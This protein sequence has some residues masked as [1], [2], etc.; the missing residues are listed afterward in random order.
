MKCVQWGVFVGILLLCVAVGVGLW[1]EFCCCQIPCPLCYLQRA[2]M[3]GVGVSL[4][5]NLASSVQVK[6]F[7]LALLWNIF[8]LFFALR[9]IAINVCHLPR[10]TSFYF[11]SWRIYTW[12]FCIFCCSLLGICLLLFLYKPMEKAPFFPRAVC[13]FCLLAVLAGCAYSALLR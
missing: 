11:L 4:F 5:G 13:A 1:I 3:V 10:E 12:S 9:H 7:A 8:G 2:A 6:Y